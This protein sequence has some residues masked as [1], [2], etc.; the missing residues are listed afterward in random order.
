MATRK[1]S[2]NGRKRSTGGTGT[3]RRATSAS[4]NYTRNTNT[5][6]GGN[7]L[8]S[9]ILTLIIAVGLFAWQNGYLD[10]FLIGTPLEQ[11]AVGTGETGGGTD[12]GSGNV[13]ATA[14]GNGN[15]DFQSIDWHWDPAESPEYYKV[16]GKAVIDYDIKPGTIEYAGI[17]DLGRTLRVNGCIT[18]DMWEGS[19]GWR[20][21]FSADGNKIPGMSSNKQGVIYSADGSESK[22]IWLLNKSHLIADS[23]GA[24]SSRRSAICGTRTENVGSGK[25][26]AVYFE[27]IACD[28]V[29]EHKG[30][31]DYLWYSAIPIYNGDELIP[32]ATVIN[33]KSSD[34]EIDMQGLRYNTLL[35]YDF[36]YYTGELTYT[37]K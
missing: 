8:L 34:G 22:P 15:A 14:L 17:D 18:Y 10:R 27:T 16:I 24:E 1:N 37:G 9:L 6:S 19:A 12:S 11:Y 7:K 32:R 13:D 5:A 26:G 31:D 33:M 4:T 30:A 21:N 35:Y 29:K 2:G 28:W 23:L 3:R 20:Q 25:G 36:D